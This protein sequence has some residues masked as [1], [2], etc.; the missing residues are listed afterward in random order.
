MYGS[1]VQTYGTE[2]TKGLPRWERSGPPAAPRHCV[3]CAAG[4]GRKPR[5]LP[6]MFTAAARHRRTDSTS[7]AFGWSWTRRSRSVGVGSEKR[8]GNVVCKFQPLSRAL[9][10]FS[11]QYRSTG[12]ILYGLG[13]HDEAEEPDRL[14][15]MLRITLRGHKQ[16]EPPKLLLQ[17][18]R[19]A[20]HKRLGLVD[21]GVGV[22]HRR[23][24][25]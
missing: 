8:P 18:T 4:P 9:H 14:S 17:L 19:S 6:V 5:P 12:K 3:S 21:Q 22:F 20:A 25:Q 23:V 10:F 7:S 2:T 13:Q 1:G 24:A 15:Y 16:F 11:S